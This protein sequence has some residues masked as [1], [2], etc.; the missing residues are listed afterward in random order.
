M[1]LIIFHS[2]HQKNYSRIM[3]KLK[4]RIFNFCAKKTDFHTNYVQ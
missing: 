2:F 4:K 1:A 3:N